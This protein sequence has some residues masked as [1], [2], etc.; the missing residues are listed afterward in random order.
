MQSVLDQTYP[1]VE[2]VV[3]DGGSSDGSATII[4]RYADRL[5][6]WV[7]ELDQGQ[8]DAVNK[9]FAR[10]TGDIMAWLNSDDKYTP[11]TLS[12]V[13]E[14]FSSFPEIDWLTSVHPVSWNQHGQAV[15]VDFTGGFSRHS[16]VRGSNFPAKGSYGRRWIQQE[17]TFWRR[18]LWDRAGGRLDTGL[19]M[20]ADF[21]LWARFYDHAELFGAQALLG[22]FRSH[23]A[24]KSVLYRDRY[25]AEAEQVLRAKGFWPTG[26]IE[27]LT[28]GIL[29]KIFR[30][31]SFARLPKYLQLPLFRIRD[32]LPVTG[33][34]VVRKGMG[35][36][37]RIHGL[38]GI[39]F[40]Y[41]H[42]ADQYSRQG[43]RG[44][45]GG[46][47][48]VPCVPQRRPRFC[49]GR[50]LQA[51]SGPRCCG[52]DPRQPPQP[53]EPALHGR[54]RTHCKLAGTAAGRPSPSARNPARRGA[55]APLVGAS[56]RP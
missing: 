42:P 9:G 55:A 14:I 4:R 16:F 8:Y 23:G 50:G 32:L 43:R 48:A 11:W 30:Q 6:Y 52:I 54:R 39:L 53:V 28:R 35:N 5:A 25:M 41:A 56:A 45:I 24:Q 22:G 12:V 26:R 47:A 38:T 27:N 1:H 33:G 36:H 40:P 10:T 7:S 31:Y 37:Y 19:H 20:A 17:S 13:A 18:S 2:Y 15:A 46:L 21:E 44:G 49:L 51:Q 29:W 34:R 3:I